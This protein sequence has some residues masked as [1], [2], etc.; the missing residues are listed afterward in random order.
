MDT[1]LSFLPLIV[2]YIFLIPFAIIIIAD[3]ISEPEKKTS[4]KSGR[5]HKTA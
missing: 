2:I 1:F 5:K 3:A 4:K